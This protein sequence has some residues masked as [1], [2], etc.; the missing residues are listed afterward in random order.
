MFADRQWAA[1]GESFTG[2]RAGTGVESELFRIRATGVSTE[3]IRLAAAAFL[4]TL[5]PRQFIRTIFAVG[6]LLFAMTF[7]MNMLG[8]WFV[9]RYREVDE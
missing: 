6:T 1:I 2:V 3:P 4:D 7:V 9:R 5:S 8:D